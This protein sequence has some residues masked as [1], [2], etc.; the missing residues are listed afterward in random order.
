MTELCCTTFT[1][2]NDTQSIK[3][4]VKKSSNFDRSFKDNFY[5][6]VLS[7]DIYSPISL[8]FKIYGEVFLRL[9]GKNT[10][11]FQ[12]PFIVF[13]TLYLILVASFL[14]FL[15]ILYILFCA[16]LLARAPLFKHLSLNKCFL[17]RFFFFP[18]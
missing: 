13:Y 10:T 18:L 4:A 2:S 3:C 8:V 9:I 7:G 17:F 1:K 6:C 14:S 16:T 15:S 12:F 11:I 5:R